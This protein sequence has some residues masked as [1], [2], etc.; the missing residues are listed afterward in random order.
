MMIVKS[1]SDTAK[2]TTTGHNDELRI[3]PPLRTHQATTTPAAG[4]H[5]NAGR[6]Y[7][8]S[9]LERR[10]YK[11]AGREQRR[12]KIFEVRC[13]P[14]CLPPTS[15]RQRRIEKAEHTE[16][17]QKLDLIANAGKSFAVTKWQPLAITVM[18]CA[19]NSLRKRSSVTCGLCSSVIT[20]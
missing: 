13:C 15:P 10:L 16:I 12:K 17:Y 18:Q 5:T 7:D 3:F 8:E 4:V 20:L 14:T 9:A 11:I 2:R 1:D 19:K 6:A